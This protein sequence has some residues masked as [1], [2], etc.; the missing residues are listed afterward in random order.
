MGITMKMII[1]AV[2]VALLAAVVYV[3]VYLAMG[4]ERRQ[5]YQDAW[6]I[7]TTSAV[8][9]GGFLG[10]I[11]LFGD[12][13]KV[14]GS[15]SYVDGVIQRGN[16]FPDPVDPS[17][18][19][20]GIGR[21]VAGRGENVLVVHPGA[22]PD[23][24]N[25]AIAAVRADCKNRA[26]V[27]FAEGAPDHNTFD[28][29]DFK[30]FTTEPFTY[31]FGGG[32]RRY[33]ASYEKWFGEGDPK[34]MMLTRL[35]ENGVAR[36]AV[37]GAHVAL[38]DRTSDKVIIGLSKR[39]SLLR[40]GGNVD[41]TDANHAAAAS[42]ELQEETGLVPGVNYVDSVVLKGRINQVFD[43]VRHEY[44][45]EAPINPTFASDEEMTI[46]SIDRK[47]IKTLLDAAAEGEKVLKVDPA[48][49]TPLLVTPK[50]PIPDEPVDLKTKEARIV[51][52]AVN[53][54]APKGIN[55]LIGV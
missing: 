42:R 51:L 26:I 17:A 31:D 54:L 4:G 36:D 34:G 24:V 5:L 15:E 16:V 55:S 44:V 39:N 18:F 21:I 7:A 52:K 41:P 2:V 53:P 23:S 14:G 37:Q 30:Q 13:L 45:A 19:A 27:A 43:D 32:P 38:Y 47:E 11:L 33:I 40:F 12:R 1:A 20:G 48:S 6:K 49:L 35:V 29:S 28:L 46:V 10:G 9:A 3:G 22:V 8:A 25:A 50:I